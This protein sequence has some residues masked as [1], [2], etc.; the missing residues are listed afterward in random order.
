MKPGG[1]DGNDGKS[2]AAAVATVTRGISLASGTKGSELVISNGVYR[3]SGAS[4]CTGGSTEAQR[5]V[6][7]GFSGN[8]D[9]VVLDAG[10]GFEGIRLASHVLVASLTVSNG[11][12]RAGCVAGGI[13]LN[14]SPASGGRYSCVISNCVVTCCTNVLG[15]NTNGAAVYMGGNDLLVDSVIRNN[16]A[17]V[18]R[19]AGVLVS[20]PANSTGDPPVI[21]RCRIEGNVAA[22]S[23]GGIYVTGGGYKDVLIE[24][25][26]IVGNSCGQ[27]GAGVFCTDNLSVCMTRCVVSNNVASTDGGYGG[28]GM[29]QQK[30]RLSLTDCLVAGNSANN[31]AGVDLVPSAAGLEFRGTNTVFRGNVAKSCGG[32]MRIYQDAQAFFDGCRFEGNRKTT[33]NNAEDDGGGGLWLAG[34]GSGSRGYGYC[35]VSNCVFA[36][37]ASYGRGGGMGCTWNTNFCGAV[38]NC[39]FTN[40]TSYYQGGGLCIREVTANPTPAVIRNCLFARNETIHEGTGSDTTD[41]NGGGILFVTYSDM[42]IENCTIVSNNI[43]HLNTAYK[44]GGIHHRWGGR[45]VNCI[46]AFNT[47]RGEPE[48]SSYWTLNDG[49]YVNCCGYPAVARFKEANGCIAS[50]PLFADAARG[51][52]SLRPGSPCRNAGG[53]ADWMAG[54]VDLAGNPRLAEAAV[55]IGCFEWTPATGLTIVIQ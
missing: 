21:R 43:R 48:D 6:I 42:A 40:N 41:S 7:R 54:A 36:C 38:V 18:W 1:D 39:V 22:Q 5:T 23:G 50:D 52:F 49:A 34:Q 10:G 3:L 8:P 32:A 19:G 25:C 29:R 20:Y 17:T 9:D 11:I 12:N 37:N 28:G 13:R 47:A 30:G 31:G 27:G 51:D 4:G 15:V 14:G 53:L 2:W 35:A 26:E 16:S 24:D 33:R 45:L 46:V 44:S 55:D